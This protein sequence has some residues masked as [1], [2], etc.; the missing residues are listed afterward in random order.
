MGHAERAGIHPEKQDAFGC[1]PVTAQIKLV[2]APGVTERVVN[3]RDWR[4]ECEPVDGVA[5]TTSG[6]D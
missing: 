5:K 4:R 3:V 1:I 2:G 6:G